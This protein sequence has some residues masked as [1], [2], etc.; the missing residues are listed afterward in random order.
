MLYL[1]LR[2]LLNI[3]SL[4]VILEGKGHTEYCSEAK[5]EKVE[6]NHCDPLSDTALPNPYLI[7]FLPPLH[8]RQPANQ[9]TSHSVW[10]TYLHLV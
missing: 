10:I 7:P 3:M 1:G 2:N 5:G 4:A 8:P 6:T 9:P